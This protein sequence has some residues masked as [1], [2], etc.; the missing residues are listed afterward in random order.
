[1][2]GKTAV[3]EKVFTTDQ[4][5]PE[6]FRLAHSVPN[7]RETVVGALCWGFM[8]ALSAWLALWCRET[9]A[10]FRLEAILTLYA[11]GGLMAWPPALFAA[12]CLSQNRTAE[13]RF[14]AFFLCLAAATIGTTAFLFALDYRSFYAQWHAMTGT[15]TWL[16]QFAFTSLAAFYQFLVLGVRLY[17]P[18]GAVA[19]M[20][21]S[22]LLARSD[23]RQRR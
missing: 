4:S 19:L 5:R 7:L 14:A 18:L 2:E 15:R 22:L 17:L 12:R 1:M 16:F 11:T 8:M 9:D 21:A 3:G 10:A 6:R 23:A 20:A 13:T